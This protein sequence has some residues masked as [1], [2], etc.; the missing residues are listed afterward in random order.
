ML[1]IEESPAGRFLMQFGRTID[2]PN[3]ILVASAHWQTS[4]GPSVSVASA[5][6]TIHDFRGFTEAL[7][8]LRYSA[9]G[10]PAIANEAARLLERAGINVTRHPSRGLDHGA[11]VPLHLMY[12]AA[13]IP[14][15]QISLIDGA[16]PAEHY[17]LGAALRPLREQN[18]LVIG[19]GSLTHNLAELRRDR[20]DAPAP[21]WVSA[22]AQWVADNLDQRRVDALLDYRKRAPYAAENHPSEEHLLPLFVAL[23]AAGE[24][25]SAKRV[26]TSY[27]YSAL[28]MDT[29]VFTRSEDREL[30]QRT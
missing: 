28:A 5:P 15:A 23:G 25:F 27:A 22:F 29:Y 2:Q 10:A 13:D 9:P 17:R 24:D 18:V 30:Y 26:H 20:L 1:A 12:P 7:Y 3:A 8:R 19:S 14:V 11:W 4:G 21:A 6:D 16:G